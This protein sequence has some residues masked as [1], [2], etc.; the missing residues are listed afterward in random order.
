LDLAKLKKAGIG[1]GV[2]FAILVSVLVI[3]MILAPGDIDDIVF[4]EQSSSDQ[5]EAAKSSQTKEQS[6][7]D[8]P[9]TVEIKT[10]RKNC[11]PS[12]PDI[13]IPP[14]PPDLDCEEIPYREF[15]V[16]HPERHGFDYD[17]DGIGCEES[18]IRISQSS[19]TN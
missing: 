7:D 13:C 2:G 8:K 10:D 9:E 19:A 16:I 18:T 12:Y 4:I 5:P 3:F 1:L 14:S 11:D 6:P 17:Q 15:K